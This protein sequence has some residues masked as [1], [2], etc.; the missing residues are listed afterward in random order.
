MSIGQFSSQVTATQLEQ[1][2]QKFAKLLTMVESDFAKKFTMTPEKHRVSAWNA[3]SNAVLAWRIPVLVSIGGD[4]QAISLDG[5]DMGTGSMMN[6][7]YMTIGYF[8]NDIGYNIPSLSIMATKSQQQ[9]MSNTLQFNITNAVKE[10]ALYNEIGLFGDGTGILAT[11][12]GT[13]SPS[14]SGGK[15]TYNIETSDFLTNRIRGQN[16]LVDVYN[17]ANVLQFSG[18]RVSNIGVSF[19]A[20]TITLSGVSTYTPVNTDKI[21][22]PN[23]GTGSYTAT[24]GSWRYG[25]Y[26]YNTTNTAGTLLGL[27]YSSVGELACP[28]VN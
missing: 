10:T 27:A 23:M 17:A 18:A 5:G 6:T 3:G 20:P 25:L 11:G 24:S 26:T 9:A 7:A 21:A 14:I 12:S 15:V 13:G 8:A 1:V 16:Q 2:R 28:T 22:F 19:T 4:Y